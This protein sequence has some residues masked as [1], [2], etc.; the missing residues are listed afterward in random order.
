M[1]EEALTK[2]K[3]GGE[4]G[5]KLQVPPEM[6]PGAIEAVKRHFNLADSIEPMTLEEAKEHRV[7]LMKGRSMIYEQP[8]DWHEGTYSFCEH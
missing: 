1:A 8:G 2:S 7:E 3:P 6:R 4:D 5:G